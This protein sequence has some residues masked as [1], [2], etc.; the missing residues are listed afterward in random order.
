MTK[1]RFLALSGNQA[2]Q[3]ALKAGQIDW[4]TGPVPDVK[5]F[6]KSYPGYQVV[7]TPLNQIVL[8]TCANP[9]L[10]CTGPQTD[11]AVR[12]ALYYGLNR[13]Q[14]NAL[15]FENTSSEISPRCNSAELK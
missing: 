6:T 2:G 14:L 10:G 8:D 15:A 1:V 3:Q 5:D 9:A 13:G 12:Q 7:T 11:P 4:Q